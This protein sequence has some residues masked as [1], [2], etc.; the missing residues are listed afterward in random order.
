M[1]DVSITLPG[2]PEVV[3]Q[4]RRWTTTT[5]GCDVPGVDLVVLV[6]SEL[7]TNAIVH[8]AS[9]EPGGTFTLHLATHE[10][11]WEIRVEDAGGPKRPVVTSAEA[12]DAGGRGLAVVSMLAKEWGVAGSQEARSVWAQVAFPELTYG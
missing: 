9:G 1:A 7:A 3:S 4:V 11:R 12:E 5:L 2:R 8:T 10:D 6:A